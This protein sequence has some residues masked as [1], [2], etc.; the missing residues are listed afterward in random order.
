MLTFNRGK[1]AIDTENVYKL[2]LFIIINT[3]IYRPTYNK[4]QRPGITESIKT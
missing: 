3:V 2:L 4:P 1:T